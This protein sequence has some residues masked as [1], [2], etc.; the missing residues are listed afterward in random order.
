DR[1]TQIRLLMN[2]IRDSEIALL[3]ERRNQATADQRW[4]STLQIGSAVL[5][6]VIGVLTAVLVVRYIRRRMAY[7]K[8][9]AEA[10]ADGDL[11]IR[12]DQS[13]RDEVGE[14]LVSMARMQGSLREMLGTI[15]QGSAELRQAAGRIATA[16]SQTASSAGQQKDASGNMAAAMEELSASI[17]DVSRNAEEANT[18]SARSG[19]LATDGYR[20][21]NHTIEGMGKISDTVSK[22]SA[23]IAELGKSS[24]EISTIISVIREIADQTNLLAL[25]A[26]IEAAR[27]GEQ[28][29]GF[30]VV[31]DEVRSLAERTSRSTDEISRMIEGLQKGAEQS[32][33]GM[34][35]AVTLVAEGVDLANKAGT[36]MD[37]IRKSAEQV[38]EVVH[39]ISNALKEQAGVSNDVASSVEQIAGMATEN[40]DVATESSAAAEQLTQLSESLDSAVRKF[41]LN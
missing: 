35:G 30:A 40:A 31:A 7:M 38:L 26:A 19:Q 13:S 24:R 5:A 25:N 4:F 34:E 23:D 22:A 16:S 36:S 32:V 20:V 14:V 39:V 11:T 6:L 1:M 27:A 2:E 18:N 15:S 28:G 12:I 10:T 33:K 8:E 9:I 17:E 3:V 37:D 21:I 41:R 29:R